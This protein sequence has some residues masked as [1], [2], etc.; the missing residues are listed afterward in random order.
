M[1]NSKKIAIVCENTKDC[2]SL[3]YQLWNAGKTV[4]F[5]DVFFPTATIIE[6]L[7]KVSC[8]EVIVPDSETVL[9]SELEAA[10]VDVSFY[11]ERRQPSFTVQI[12]DINPESKM[13]VFSSG[14]TSS[15][16]AIV[17]S[18]E[19]V[20]RAARKL[21][22][23]IAVDVEGLA[24]IQAPLSHLWAI[25]S[26]MTF[27]IQNRQFEFGS[28]IKEKKQLEELNPVIYVSVPSVIEKRFLKHNNI[29]HYV[30]SGSV[31]SETLE[32]MIRERGKSIQNCYGT[33]EI[34]GCAISAYDGPVNKLYPIVNCG[35]DL[36]D[37]GTWIC[38]D[39]LMDGY[40]G[41]EEF[42]KKILQDGRFFISD[43]LR[44]NQ[45]GTYTVLGRSDTV[46]ALKNGIKIEL[47]SMDAQIKKLIEE[48]DACILYIDD[49]LVLITESSIPDIQNRINQFN[50]G[51][52][53]YSRIS[54]HMIS[55]SPFPRTE[56]GKLKRTKLKEMVK[57]GC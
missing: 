48:C 6:L 52:P 50:E 3:I 33:S 38:T 12:D 51:Q 16:K 24:Y 19:T 4:V 15:A 7:G 18:V 27:I 36:C 25:C 55:G 56:L 57:G 14:T 54:D 44:D 53:Y 13:I 2:Y 28:L 40:L 21:A 42:T 46:V 17:L 30:C 34:A 37:D 5:L 43:I 8:A 47:E 11:N 35:F 39:T 41:Q 31:C 32:K 49:K 26:S 10:G 20:V 29:K 22:G 23:Y 45:D 1:R 9:K